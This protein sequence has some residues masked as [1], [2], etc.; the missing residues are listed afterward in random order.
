MASRVAINVADLTRNPPFILSMLV[1]PHVQRRE[2]VDAGPNLDDNAV[3]LECPEV[4]ARAVVD[5]LRIKD[6]TTKRYA[7]RAYLE[8]S[9]GGWSKI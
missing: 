6:R 3:I 7:T 8:G 4:Q 5:I 1:G 9:R 2:T